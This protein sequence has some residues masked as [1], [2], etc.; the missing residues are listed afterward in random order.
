MQKLVVEGKETDVGYLEIRFAPECELCRPF[1][2]TPPDQASLTG[3]KGEMKR[4]R[5][6][7]RRIDA[8]PHPKPIDVEF[9]RLR[10]HVGLARISNRYPQ[11]YVGAEP[12]SNAENRQVRKYDLRSTE[13]FQIPANPPLANITNITSSQ[14]LLR[15]EEPI[16]QA[17]PDAKR[18]MQDVPILD[19]GNVQV[20]KQKVDD[21][22]SENTV[23][24]R[25]GFNEEGDSFLESL[26]RDLEVMK[27]RRL[28]LMKARD[29]LKSNL[30]SS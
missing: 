5:H 24:K 14:S 2:G 6:K 13:C 16:A 29:E 23:I 1:G 19:V 15:Q 11:R 20:K 18:K 10:P 7:E 4:E 22:S 17:N 9:G 8:V 25:E 26:Q 27:N 3:S 21:A 28:L 12:G 30:L